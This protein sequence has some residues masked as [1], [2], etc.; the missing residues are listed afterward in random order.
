MAC[1]CRRTNTEVSSHGLLAIWDVVAAFESGESLRRS[2]LVCEVRDDCHFTDHHRAGR[3]HLVVIACLMSP[4]RC[5]REHIVQNKAPAS[6]TR[7]RRATPSPQSQTATY[8]RVNVPSKQLKSDCCRRNGR[9]E[10]VHVI[11]NLCRVWKRMSPSH[12]FRSHTTT[13]PRMEKPTEKR[14]G[15]VTWGS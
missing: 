5:R 14:H 2:E 7:R 12:H 13:I 6:V 11:C 15:S 10:K 4:S 3:Y 8:R 1:G 9:E